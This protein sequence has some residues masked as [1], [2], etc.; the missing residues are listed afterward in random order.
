MTLF[1]AYAFI[2]LN[3]KSTVNPREFPKVLSYYDP[4]K[5]LAKFN[6]RDDLLNTN[7]GRF[8]VS[9]FNKNS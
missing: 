7:M 2:S 4:L 3:K 8:T 9:V 1:S 5:I 6:V